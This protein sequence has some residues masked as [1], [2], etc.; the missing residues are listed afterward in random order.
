MEKIKYVDL[1]TKYSKRATSGIDISTVRH[2]IIKEVKRKSEQLSGVEPF[3]QEESNPDTVKKYVRALQILKSR[4]EKKLKVLSASEHFADGLYKTHFSH[5]HS[6][7]KTPTLSIQDILDDYYKSQHEQGPM[8]SLSL[9]YFLDYL[10]SR[11]DFLKSIN[12]LRF[13]FTS[14]KYR[15]MVWRI[16]TGITIEQTAKPTQYAETL[17][18]TTPS[19]LS[20][21]QEKIQSFSLETHSRFRKEVS[22]IYQKFIAQDKYNLGI[23]KVVVDS[24]KRYILP[25]DAVTLNPA[26]RDDDYLCVMNA[27]RSVLHQLDDLFNDFI[28]SEGYFRWVRDYQKLKL[29]NFNLTID[30]EQNHLYLFE[31]SALMNSL[32]NELM[33]SCMKLT[34]QKQQ[35]GDLHDTSTS[36][37]VLEDD[38]TLLDVTALSGSTSMLASPSAKDEEDEDE[39]HAPGELFNNSSKIYQIHQN[40]DRLLQEIDRINFLKWKV[41]V[42]ASQSSLYSDPLYTMQIHVLDQTKDQLVQEIGELVR[43]KAKYE[44][45]EQ[46]EALL[47]GQCHVSIQQV[48]QDDDPA[49]LGKKVVYFLIEIDQKH[50]NTGWAVKRRYNDFDALHRKLREKF[51]IVDDFDFPSKSNPIWAMVRNE[52]KGNRMKALEMYLQVTIFLDNSLLAPRG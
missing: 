4:L 13:C 23:P 21:S 16:N 41:S 20:D 49:P 30:N 1:V 6:P 35:T 32:E 27:Q 22:K 38:G 10:E 31:G 3:D 12:L 28:H 47:P 50:L 42:S 8:I 25:P 44:S 11:K 19:S 24:F 29:L 15:Q 45:Q 2:E 9:Y 46:R 36:I 39:V 7:L 43:Q 26:K 5:I 18:I 17:P 33:E 40:M 34:G 52:V 14:E 51:P 37:I 48:E